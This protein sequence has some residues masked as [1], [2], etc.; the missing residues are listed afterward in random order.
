MPIKVHVNDAFPLMLSGKP[1]TPLY[2]Y[3]D[4][5]GEMSFIRFS[6]RKVAD[7]EP[8]LKSAAKKCE[9]K[10]FIGWGIEQ[11]IQGQFTAHNPCGVYLAFLYYRRM[12]DTIHI[13][14]YID[15]LI[16]EVNLH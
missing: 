6:D 2:V 5:Y 10:E 7:V 12:N 4:D 9:Y 15:E 3:V 14:F 13:H 8:L 16:Q 11:T 1:T